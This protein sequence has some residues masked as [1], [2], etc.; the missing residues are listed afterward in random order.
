MKVSLVPAPFVTAEMAMKRSVS[1]ALLAIAILTIG[2]ACQKQDQVSKMAEQ[3]RTFAE[4][5]NPA[6]KDKP[7][8]VTLSRQNNN[9][10]LG[11]CICARVCTSSG[12][13]SACGCS[14]ANCGTCAS[15]TE[16]AP[17]DAVFANTLEEKK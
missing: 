8:L 2:S 3:I 12:T 16:L 4:S 9:G 5:N 7:L 1:A 14:P 10:G 13:C 15:E 17:I 11:V 6:L